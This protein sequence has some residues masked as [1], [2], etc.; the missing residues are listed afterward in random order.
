MLYYT[1]F[2]LK[3]MEVL[4]LKCGVSVNKIVGGSSGE[5]IEVEHSTVT[6]KTDT[7]ELKDH[8]NGLKDEE[9][10]AGNYRLR[11]KSSTAEA[12]TPNGP[13]PPKMMKTKAVKRKRQ[14]DVETVTE[15]TVGG[16]KFDNN[17]LDNVQK[18]L[19]VTLEIT[20]V[21]GNFKSSTSSTSS[22][23]SVE[24]PPSTDK[25]PSKSIDERQVEDEEDEG[26]DVVMVEL[27]EEFVVEQLDK[28]SECDSCP[29]QDEAGAVEVF[30]EE[31]SHPAHR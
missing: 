1:C 25:Q 29:S 24:S 5:F 27:D 22:T 13:P 3:V 11:R 26:N 18:K 23:S 12:P 7:E 14:S 9:G 2:S 30:G 28:K 21:S 16:E 17:N 6:I 19:P 31:K 20:P 4:Q 10:P 8:M 15:Q